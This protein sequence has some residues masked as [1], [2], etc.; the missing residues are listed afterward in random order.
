MPI[1]CDIARVCNLN[2]NIVV[3][4]ARRIVGKKL[5]CLIKFAQQCVRKLHRHA[6]HENVNDKII[7]HARARVHLVN[8]YICLQYLYSFIMPI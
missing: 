1:L 7:R 4:G 6:R 2:K 8:V 5:C 3:H